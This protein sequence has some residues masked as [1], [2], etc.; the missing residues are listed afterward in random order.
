MMKWYEKADNRNGVF[1]KKVDTAKVL[2]YL[3]S[4]DWYVTRFIES[5][6]AIPAEVTAKRAEARLLI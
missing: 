6:V 3:A 5:A 4:T 1:N 2:N